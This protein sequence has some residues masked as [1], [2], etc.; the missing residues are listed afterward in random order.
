MFGILFLKRRYSVYTDNTYIKK[1]LPELYINFQCSAE[2]TPPGF[3]IRVVKSIIAWGNTVKSRSLGTFDTA[4]MN[5][6][7]HYP[8]LE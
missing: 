4:N 1:M 8:F 6:W 5:K 3:T 2:L 7:K